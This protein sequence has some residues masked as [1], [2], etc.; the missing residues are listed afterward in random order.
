MTGQTK[1]DVADSAKFGGSCFDVR[2]KMQSILQPK[3]RLA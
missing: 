1:E 2:D 3:R